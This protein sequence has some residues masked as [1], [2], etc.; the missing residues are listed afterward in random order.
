M[1]AAGTLRWFHSLPIAG[2][3]LATAS[4]AVATP[5]TLM[6]SQI[7][8]QGSGGGNDDFVEVYNASWRSI[9]LTGLKVYHSSTSNILMAT[10]ASGSLGSGCYYLLAYSGY[11]G[12]VAADASLSSSVADNTSVGIVAASVTLDGVGFVNPAPPGLTFTE[13]TPLADLAGDIDQA[14]ERN[15][16]GA[17]GNWSDTN[18]NAT[19]FT[20]IVPATPRSSASPCTPVDSVFDDSFD[21]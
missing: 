16:G 8:T 20:L 6:I 11:T 5:P 14:Y 9:D 21:A 3:L 18:D 4:L 1:R 13:G 10:V 7:R 12:S 15:P 2:A 17:A 19:D